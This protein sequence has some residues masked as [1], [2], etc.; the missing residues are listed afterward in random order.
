MVTLA[1]YT[2]LFGILV[3]IISDFRLV[4]FLLIF[5]QLASINVKNIM[6]LLF[7]VLLFLKMHN[8]RYKA[9][10]HVV[11]KYFLHFER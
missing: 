4:A 6:E 2:K 8:F 1:S 5:T 11:H 10:F 3:N 7:L 9:F